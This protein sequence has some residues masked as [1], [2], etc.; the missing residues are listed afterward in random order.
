MRLLLN[1]AVMQNW[2]I[3]CSCVHFSDNHGQHYS[4]KILKNISHVNDAGVSQLCR[5][6]I[7]IMNISLHVFFSQP[8][9]KFTVTITALR[10]RLTAQ[11]PNCSL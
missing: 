5:V 7:A 8:Q 2:T 11:T 10:M 4:S 3:A 9:R 6:V 1:D